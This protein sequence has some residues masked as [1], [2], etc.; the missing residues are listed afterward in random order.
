MFH[1]PLST[2]VRH[3]LA[4]DLAVY[5]ACT[6]FASVT[7]MASTY[8]THR[9][10]GGYATAGYWFAACI[11]LVASTG[12][13]HRRL[14]RWLAVAVATVLALLVPLTILVTRRLSGGD[15]AT[16]ASAWSAQPEVWVIERS[17]R[18][19]VDT[20]TPY[21]DVTNLGRPPVVDDYTPYGPVMPVF[22]LPR[23]LVTG[24]GMD[25]PVLL[26]LTDARVVFIAVAVLCAVAAWS[27]LRRPPVPIAAAQLAVLCP[28]T[29]QTFAVAA[30]DLAVLGLLVLALALA[31][32]DRWVLAGVVMAGVVSA[33]LTAAPAL[34][35]LAVLL[36]ARSGWR[37]AA[38]F[39]GALT[40][41]AAAVTVPVALRDPAAFV[42][43][44]IAFPAGSAE[45]TSPA[46]SPLPGHL[47]ASTGSAGHAIA[48][49]L[50]CAAALAILAWLLLHPPVTGSDAALRIAVGLA[51]A[52]L[53]TPATRWGY[54]VY[55]LVLLGVRLWLR[56]HHTNRTTAPGQV[57]APDR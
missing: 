44:V 28:A 12:P 55:P 32:T 48:I 38:G 47:I 25:A 24:A 3:S 34:V 27:I 57:A 2:L 15:F 31:L 6:A 1:L 37:A 19:L 45:V 9:V 30:P 52:T 33:K 18:L 35:V 22:G 5:L 49:G 23:A 10:W 7:A 21:V 29:A 26:A 11:V 42:E 36:G 53:L 46:A 41:G 56:D 17:A 54:L 43:H 51:T 8:E 13:R 50:L 40:V 20:G 14:L 39:L 16:D 4:R